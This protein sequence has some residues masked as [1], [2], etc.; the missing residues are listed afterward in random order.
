MEFEPDQLEAAVTYIR[1]ME[2]V[3]SRVN[4]E[5]ETE[6]GVWRFVFGDDVRYAANGLRTRL[7]KGRRFRV[8]GGTSSET[9]SMLREFHADDLEGAAA[10]V[11]DV[12]AGYHRVYVEE[13][14]EGGW[15]YVL[16]TDADNVGEALQK[17]TRGRPFRVWAL[18]RL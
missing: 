16:N 3:V 1:G 12:S 15:R 5:E 11:R 10:F 17:V 2:R 8:T 7:R 6:P 4:V 18:R 9:V 13:W 14:G